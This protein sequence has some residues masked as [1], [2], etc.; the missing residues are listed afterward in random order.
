MNA[1][2]EFLEE[3]ERCELEPEEQSTA[4]H[5]LIL[6]PKEQFAGECSLVFLSEGRSAAGCF[7]VGGRSVAPDLTILGNLKNLWIK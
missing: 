2:E 6:L 7:S 4:A 5:S 3:C 1:S